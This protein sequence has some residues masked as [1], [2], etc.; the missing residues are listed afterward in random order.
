MHGSLNDGLIQDFMGL[1]S[2]SQFQKKGYLDFLNLAGFFNKD[3]PNELKWSYKLTSDPNFIGF[4]GA[5]YLIYKQPF[6]YD[7]TFLKPVKTFGDY[8]ILRTKLALPLFYLQ[9]RSI[10]NSEIMKFP[11]E[12]RRLLLFY[13]TV[14]NDDVDKTFSTIS[15]KTDSSIYRIDTL[16]NQVNL[17]NHTGVVIDNFKPDQINLTVQTNS[18]SIM[19][20]SIPDH[21]GWKLSID[22]TE[23][24]KVIVNGGL[25]G[26]ELVP[27]KHTIE[28]L[29]TPV[30]LKTGIICSSLSIVILLLLLLL[31]K[32]KKLNEKI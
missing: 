32:I 10:S 30:K 29:Y 25:I 9:K 28:L 24:K 11:P 16:L 19:C 18:K 1:V 8:G 23:A 31:I 5:K 22:G 12:K 26:C 21:N 7:S 20:S 2:Y 14:L 15:A 27:G 4:V 3:D 17:L 6:N 13:N